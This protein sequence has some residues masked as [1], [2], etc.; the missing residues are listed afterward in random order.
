MQTLLLASLVSLS[1]LMGN[2]DKST[3]PIQN[4]KGFKSLFDGKTSKGWHVY[5]NKSGG[6]A[7]KV[8]DGVLNLDAAYKKANKGNG[9]GD[10]IT[11]GAYEN[12]H[13][14]MEWKISPNGN[15]GIIF[16]AQE[17]TAKY[18]ESW[19]TG[20]EMQVLDN[21]G[22]SDGKIIKH[23]AGN[24]YDLVEGKEGVVKP[25]GE[26]NLAEVISN[27]GKLELMLNGV[28]VVS[29][30]YGDD[31]WKTLIAGSKFKTKPDFGKLF[32]GH[33]ALQDHGNDVYFRNIR[34]KQ[35]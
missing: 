14:K 13:L 15:S 12:F 3:T 5:G 18:K 24:L 22:H 16:Y 27:K 29:T 4:E 30:T 33:I 2:P 1:L 32:K 6:E 35:L 25:V 34:I 21:D 10:L 20:P 19:W 11:D 9:G 28:V 17:D 26:W 31:N 7:W 8:E 23:R